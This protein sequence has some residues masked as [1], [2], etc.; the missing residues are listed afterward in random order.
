MAYL[1]VLCLVTVAVAIIAMKAAV[2][3]LAAL[4]LTVTTK[5]KEHKKGCEVEEEAPL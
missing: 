5:I 3:C 2:A 1:F 4:I